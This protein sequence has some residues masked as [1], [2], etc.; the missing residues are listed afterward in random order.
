MGSFTTEEDALAYGKNIA[1]L[2]YTR[3]D[4]IVVRGG[5]WLHPVVLNSDASATIKKYF[6]NAKRLEQMY[7]SPALL[8]NMKKSEKKLA[9]TGN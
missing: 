8:H 9:T 4:L 5:V 1:D 7:N 3:L 6:P 2:V